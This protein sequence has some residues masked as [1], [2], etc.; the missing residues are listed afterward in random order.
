MRSTKAVVSSIGVLAAL[1]TGAQGCTPELPA[2]GL[3]DDA[4]VDGAGR[5]PPNPLAGD[6]APSAEGAAPDGS[7][8]ADGS[9]PTDGSATDGGSDGGTACAAS[10]Q[11][12]GDLKPLWSTTI[13]VGNYATV[14][15]DS[16]DNVIVA[17]SVSGPISVDGQTFVVPDAGR[18]PTPFVLK[19]DPDGHVL[20]NRVFGGTGELVVMALGPG[21][22]IYIAGVASGLDLGG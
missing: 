8:P 4:S 13:G 14:A 6:G 20:W 22:D 10:P 19:L 9:T 16:A 1:L 21:G 3:R 5:T 17:G 15:A 7:T 12:Y 11:I 2:S 18:A